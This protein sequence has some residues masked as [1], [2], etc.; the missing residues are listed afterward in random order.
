[1]YPIFSFSGISSTLLKWRPMAIWSAS[2]DAVF[3]QSAILCCF[4]RTEMTAPQISL[5]SQ[6]CSPIMARSRLSQQSSRCAGS[7]DL[8]KK[9]VHFP[10][11]AHVASSHLGSMPSLNRWKSVPMIKRLGARMLLYRHQKSSTVLKVY[12]LRR[13]WPHVACFWR[14]LGL[15]NHSVHVCSSG[16]F[17]EKSGVASAIA[18][19]I[20]GRRSR[21][22]RAGCLAPPSRVRTFLE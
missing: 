22:S 2:L 21:R 5:G 12:T 1:M 16:C 9:N 19:S 8:G 13:V 18:T 14:P 6:N 4:W 15:S 20:T 17:A 3:V 10:P 7:L 11:F